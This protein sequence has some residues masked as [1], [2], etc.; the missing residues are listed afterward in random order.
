MTR[1]RQVPAAGPL[2]LRVARSNLLVAGAALG[3][4]AV[5]LVL[6]QFVVLRAALL[7]DL[8]VQARIVGNNS[9]AALMFQDQRAATENLAGL[10]LSPAVDSAAILDPRGV[11]LAGYRRAGAAPP[12]V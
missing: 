11:P 2:D 8:Q 12:E 10:A 1:A 6:F 4:A 7:G 9:S 3:V 5:L